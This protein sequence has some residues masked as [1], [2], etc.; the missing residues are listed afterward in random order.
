M[1]WVGGDVQWKGRRQKMMMPELPP[2][3]LLLLPGADLAT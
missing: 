2:P 1:Q 3:G